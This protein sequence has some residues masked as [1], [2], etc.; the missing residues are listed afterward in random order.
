MANIGLVDTLPFALVAVVNVL[1]Y[2]VAFLLV[3]F[4]CVGSGAFHFRFIVHSRFTGRRDHWDITGF[5]K[6]FWEI[7]SSFEIYHVTQK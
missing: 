1:L 6:A 2:T 7:I 4:R 5:A 3:E